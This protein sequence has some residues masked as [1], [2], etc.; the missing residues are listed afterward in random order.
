MGVGE[1][2]PSRQ[3][4]WT[5]PWRVVV[6]GDAAGRILESDLVNDSHRRRG[7]RTRAGSSPD[8]RPGA[9]GRRATARSTRRV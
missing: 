3:L 5:M 7:S 9:G 8:A 1:V 6:I 4:P 2:N